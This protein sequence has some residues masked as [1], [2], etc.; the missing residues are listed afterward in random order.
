MKEI[1]SDLRAEQDSLDEIVS[2]INSDAW[3]TP[4]LAAGWDIRDQIGHLAFFDERATESIV[5]PEAFLAV[6]ETAVADIDE[7]IAS[8]LDVARHSDPDELLS[9]WRRARSAL[10]DAFAPLDPS[11]RLAWY[12]PPVSLENKR[13]FQFQDNAI[14]ML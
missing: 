1:V 11:A 12:G 10:L 9:H 8:H 14:N 6:V 4:T 2:R 3:N 7:Y 13:I 5:T